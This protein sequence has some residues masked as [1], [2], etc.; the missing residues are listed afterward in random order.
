MTTAKQSPLWQALSDANIVEGDAPTR[1]MLS[2]PWY[3]KALLA[4]SGWLGAIFILAFILAIFSFFMEEPIACFIMSFALFSGA[5]AILSTPKSEFF[6]HLALAF[7]L[8]GQALFC[9]ALFSQNFDHNSWLILGVLQAILAYVMPSFLHRLFST[10]FAVAAFE[11]VLITY[12][13]PYILGSV[14]IFPIV[15]LGLRE[16][17]FIKH[18]QRNK[19]VF[20]GLVIAMLALNSQQ[21][22]SEDLFALLS[23]A[24][25][26]LITISPWLIQG[27]FI[28]AA[29]FTSQQLLQ[30]NSIKL[31]D[32]LAIAIMLI[33]LILA[34]ITLKA[35]G[36]LAGLII[37]LLGFNQSNRV[38][39]GLGTI[40]LLVYCSSYYYYMEETLL[41]KAGLLFI[42]G[43]VALVCR[44]ALI[45]VLPRLAL[46]DNHHKGA[47][48]K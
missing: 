22:L 4:M 47:Y 33:T 34:F 26:Y 13:Q 43:A 30:K 37:M 36:V 10:A 48:E 23:T 7:S 46:T 12:G 6:E 45:K 5:Y 3:V 17:T 25:D 18:Y 9:W 19:G 44:L 35:P 15:W 40:S 21:F 39:I 20:Y 28:A 41:F 27:I 32:K 16:F 1:N 8:A 31:N 29:L 14:L 2:S 11:I 24:D 38:A 42:L